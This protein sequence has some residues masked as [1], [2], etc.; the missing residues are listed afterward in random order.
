MMRRRIMRRSRRI[1]IR[2]MIELRAC[3]DAMKA[4]KRFEGASGCGGGRGWRVLAVVM[5]V[6][7]ANG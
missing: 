5:E 1:T 3:D 4:F 6:M 7:V 2:S